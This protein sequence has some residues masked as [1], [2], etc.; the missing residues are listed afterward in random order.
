MPGKAREKTDVWPHGREPDVREIR[1]RHLHVEAGSALS[2]SLAK[3]YG[4]YCHDCHT[5]LFRTPEQEKELA[6]RLARL[7]ARGPARPAAVDLRNWVLVCEREDD[8]GAQQIADALGSRGARVRPQREYR[9]GHPAICVSTQGARSRVPLGSDPALARELAA[10]GFD[11][12]IVR[13]IRGGLPGGADALV[14]TGAN[15]RATLYACIELA[16]AISRRRV[17]DQMEIRQGGAFD[18]R[19]CFFSGEEAML[20]HGTSCGYFS[21]TEEDLLEFVRR[22]GSLLQ[23][24]WHFGDLTPVTFRGLLG[25]EAAPARVHRRIARLRRDLALC[26][27]YHVM[28]VTMLGLLH[29]TWALE[30]LTRRFPD[31]R[32]RGHDLR[33]GSIRAAYCPS[34]PMTR[35]FWAAQVRELFETFEDLSGLCVWP[36]DVGAAI[37]S[38]SRC[39]NYPYVQRVIDYIRIAYDQMRAARPDGLLIVACNQLEWA[40]PEIALPA[41]AHCN[42]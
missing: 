24:G 35:K 39:T 34:R 25:A 7:P 3:L 10:L 13:F 6:E 18:M 5:Q 9:R 28:G 16:K 41:V 22:K 19:G 42:A 4:S 1:C 23:I 37:C 36:F 31:M 15:R 21:P 29:R 27:K 11:P 38:C 20:F 26:K 14:V 32:T 2:K 12:H 8:V 33:A 17:T 40:L 30:E